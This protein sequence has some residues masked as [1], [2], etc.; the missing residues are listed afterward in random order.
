MFGFHR[1][2]KPRPPKE[3]GPIRI[4]CYNISGCRRFDPA[5]KSHCM[6]HTQVGVKSCASRITK[7]EMIEECKNQIDEIKRRIQYVKELK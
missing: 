4:K 5:V 2:E 7:I 6:A 3:K 1:S